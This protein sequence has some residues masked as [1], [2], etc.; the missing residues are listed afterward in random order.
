MAEDISWG[1]LRA[2]TWI[3]PLATRETS[4]ACLLLQG[5]GQ[6]RADLLPLRQALLEFHRVVNQHILPANDSAAISR[7]SQNRTHATRSMVGHSC[8][9]AA[10]KGRRAA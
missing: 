5:E 10:V 9:S 7:D 4:S 3:N 1:P 8:A 6:Q 2:P